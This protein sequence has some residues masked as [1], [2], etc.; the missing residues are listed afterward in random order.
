[1]KFSHRRQ[2]ERLIR[3][4]LVQLFGL[5]LRTGISADSVDRLAQECLLEA[6]RDV[7]SR[8]SRNSKVFDAQDYGGVLR[9]WHR[10][11]NYLSSDGFPRPLTM[12]GKHGLRRLIEK[13]YPRSQ[14][15]RV[16]KALCEAGLIKKRRDGKWLPTDRC[17]ILPELN[18]E[19]LAHV[20]EGIAMLVQTVTKNV[21]SQRGDT[22][23]ERSAKVRF[24]PRKATPAFKAFMNEQGS[25]FLGAVDDWLESRSKPNRNRGRSTS[26]AGVFTFAFIDD[27]SKTS[28][29][30]QFSSKAS[31]SL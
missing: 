7:G 17:A 26:T 1:M 14:V 5:Q 13:F 4:A 30:P 10:D 9:E 31:R 2:Y 22:L 21:T 28:S 16:L 25:T 11:A 18:E 12:T 19:L 6:V 15:M 27:V 29:A 24:F 23:F 3:R 8:S 20:V